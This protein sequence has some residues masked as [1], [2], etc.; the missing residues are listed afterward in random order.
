MRLELVYY[1]RT[2]S[3]PLPLSYRQVLAELSKIEQ[4]NASFTSR[5]TASYGLQLERTYGPCTLPL[6]RDVIQ[7]TS[8]VIQDIDKILG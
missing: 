8:D 7:K 6:V 5:P 4:F 2:L 3:P 1:C